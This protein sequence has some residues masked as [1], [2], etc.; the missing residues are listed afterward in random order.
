MYLIISWL[1]L[2]EYVWD[3]VAPRQCA[4]WAAQGISTGT[5]LH[6]TLMSVELSLLPLLGAR[7]IRLCIASHILKT[8][9]LLL[10]IH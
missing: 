9:L 1:V 7:L 4:G 3:V 5:H 8:H 6:E 2:H 10:I